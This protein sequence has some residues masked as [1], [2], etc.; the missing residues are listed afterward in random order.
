MMPSGPEISHIPSEIPPLSTNTEI[1]PEVLHDLH[2]NLLVESIQ[3]SNNY[4]CLLDDNELGC[5]S[6]VYCHCENKA[7]YNT[8]FYTG[9]N[10]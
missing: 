10:Q 1:K 9:A 4:P 2:N 3:Q 5:K 8:E 6:A 7:H